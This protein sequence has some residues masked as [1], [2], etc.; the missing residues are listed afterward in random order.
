MNLPLLDQSKDIPGD[1][2]Y[3]DGL[4]FNCTTCGNCCT[5]GPGYVFL[6]EQ[7]IELAAEHRKV[8]VAEFKKQFC[9][10]VGGKI[11]LKEMRRSDGLHDCVFLTEVPVNSAKC[12]L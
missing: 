9:R 2:W 4:E 1:P 5:G 10:K 6:S 12:E 7:E 8:S 11:S 3:A